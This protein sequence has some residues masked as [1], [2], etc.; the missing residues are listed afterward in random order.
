MG[1]GLPMGILT[2]LMH[3]AIKK[4]RATMEGDDSQVLALDGT[5]TLPKSHHGQS[6]PPFLANQISNFSSFVEGSWEGG[7][8][9]HENYTFVA[10]LLLFISS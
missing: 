6:L 7:G 5:L 1:R 8:Q 3:S 10:S 9:R 2:W 4:A